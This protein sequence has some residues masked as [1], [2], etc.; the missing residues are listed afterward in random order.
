MRPMA[1]V[2]LGLA[3]SLPFFVSCPLISGTTSG[4][5]GL[6]RNADYTAQCV[7]VYWKGWE[8]R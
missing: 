1:V 6:Y 7:Y 5:S 8:S 3:M 4:I 2:Q